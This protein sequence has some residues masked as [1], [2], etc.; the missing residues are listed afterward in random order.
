M[1]KRLFS[2][3]AVICLFSLFL[4]PVH[5]QEAAPGTDTITA[6]ETAAEAVITE[7][8]DIE[9]IDPLFS[10]Y[11]ELE[12]MLLEKYSNGSLENYNLGEIEA[13]RLKAEKENRS[14]VIS[15]LDMLSFVV[16]EGLSR[17]TEDADAERVISEIQAA[18]K[19][20]RREISNRKGL[21][22]ATGISLGTAIASSSI[23]T[24]SAIFSS[25]FYNKYTAAES[26]D[27]AGF[28]LF[29][30]QF[31]EKVSLFSAITSVVSGLSAGI[32]AAVN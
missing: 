27:Q 11:I 22:A 32:L 14:D 4:F 23:F 12:T 13:L 16:S 29:W 15:R 6:A 5:S 25:D 7:D 8:I 31:L 26:A 21:E 2:F 18:E 19:E 10:E 30:W 3:T 17:Q 24:L 20:Y 1:M 9:Y 28:Y